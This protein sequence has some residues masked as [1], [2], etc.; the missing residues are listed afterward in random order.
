MQ[1]DQPPNVFIDRYLPGASAEEREEAAANLERFV[2]VLVRIDERIEREKR[3]TIRQ[4]R[5]SALDSGI[6]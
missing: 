4:N 3:D 6:S 2:A 1:D 5:D